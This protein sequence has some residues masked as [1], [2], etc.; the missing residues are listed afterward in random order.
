MVL[1]IQLHCISFTSSKYCMIWSRASSSDGGDLF[2]SYSLKQN[3]GLRNCGPESKQRP[4]HNLTLPPLHMLHS[5][6]QSFRQSKLREF[7]LHTCTMECCRAARVWVAKST[8]LNRRTCSTCKKEHILW[9]Q[10][11]Q[12]FSWG[13]SLIRWLDEPSHVSQASFLPCSWWNLSAYSYLL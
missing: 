5:A 8:R 4:A 1:R 12:N 3:S 9:S 6:W 13:M 7:R 11:E 2:S 10:I